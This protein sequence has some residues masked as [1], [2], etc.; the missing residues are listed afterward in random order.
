MLIERFAKHQFLN[1][2][3]YKTEKAEIM[4]KGGKVGRVRVGVR[5]LGLGFSYFA[6][7]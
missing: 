3:Q 4:L 5:N 6:V 7:F 2:E 1:S